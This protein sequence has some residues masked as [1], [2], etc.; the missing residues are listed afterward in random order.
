MWRNWWHFFKNQPSGKMKRQKWGETAKTRLPKLFTGQ[1]TFSYFLRNQS[2]PTGNFFQIVHWVGSKP[3]HLD[4]RDSVW[5]MKS[6]RFG[7]WQ[8]ILWPKNH[9]FSCQDTPARKI[10][11]FFSP[12]TPG[13]ELVHFG[14]NLYILA[15]QDWLLGGKIWSNSSPMCPREKKIF[16]LFL[17]NNPPNKTWVE[18]FLAGILH[19]HKQTTKA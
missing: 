2:Q 17:A 16:E 6:G 4:W 12:T 19:R 11:T 5:R 3:Q 7:A 8:E 13:K 14:E 18:F 9:I 15:T 1:W 10:L